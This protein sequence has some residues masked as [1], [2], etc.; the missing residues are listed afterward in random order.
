MQT[1]G[2]SNSAFIGLEFPT[3]RIAF[4]GSPLPGRFADRYRDY[5]AY[6]LLVCGVTAVWAKYANLRT[7]TVFP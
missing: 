7:I 2:L 5:V 1:H 4:S 3:D 6:A